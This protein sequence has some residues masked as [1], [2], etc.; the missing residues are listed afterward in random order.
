MKKLNS[1]LKVRKIIKYFVYID[2]KCTNNL[3]LYYYAIL[4]VQ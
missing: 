2:K 3:F 4:N 1:Q